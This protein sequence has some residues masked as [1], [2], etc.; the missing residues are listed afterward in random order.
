[1]R[2]LHREEPRAPLRV[3]LEAHIDDGSRRM[4][5]EVGSVPLVIRRSELAL[6]LLVLDD[7]R[8]DDKA[9]EKIM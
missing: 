7:L 8:S 2:V 9:R 1:M 6:Q 5:L 4:R 3:V